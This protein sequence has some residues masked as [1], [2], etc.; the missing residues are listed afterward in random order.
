MERLQ[1]ERRY[2]ERNEYK[3][4]LTGEFYG[5]WNF[6]KFKADGCVI[7]KEYEPFQMLEIVNVIYDWFNK[8]IKF[9]SETE[10]NEIL[11]TLPQTLFCLD[12]YIEKEFDQLR[13]PHNKY[14]SKEI[15]FKKNY[16]LHFSNGHIPFAFIY[17]REFKEVIFIMFKEKD[18]EK[19]HN[20]FF[21]SDVFVDRSSRGMD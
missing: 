4:G 15:G 11:V 6:E 10:P 14:I 1:R 21:T 17:A 16:E 18:I 20:Y 3:E 7:L 2:L 9:L 19:I 8:E 12:S 5:K 13:I